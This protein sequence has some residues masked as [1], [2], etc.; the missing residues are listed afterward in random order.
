MKRTSLIG[1]ALAATAITLF[2][3]AGPSANPA[4][5]LSTHHNYVDA[6]FASAFPVPAPDLVSALSD[7]V[8]VERV[9][10]QTNPEERDRH[11]PRVARPV[12][13]ASE[14]APDMIATAATRDRGTEDLNG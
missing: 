3:V 5:T 14:S 1:A 4:V 13:N 8:D 10:R 12:T 7:L 11:R 9:I 2:S 6:T